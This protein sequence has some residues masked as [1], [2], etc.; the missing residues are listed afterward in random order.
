[1]IALILL[2]AE[3]SLAGPPLHPELPALPIHLT[4]PFSNITDHKT[5]SS[6]KE[7]ELLLESYHYDLTAVRDTQLVP[8]VFATDIPHHLASLPVPEKTSTF[9]RLLL[10]SVVKVNEDIE[11][12]RAEVIVLRDKVQEG[13]ALTDEESGWLAALGQDYGVD[14]AGIDDV[15]FGDLLRR[16]DSVPVAMVMA[17]GIDE[18][19]W[20]TSRFAIEGNALYGQH[21]SSKGGKSIT[22]A[23]GK[24]KVAAFDDIY[25]STASYIHNLNATRA[26]ASFRETRERMRRE[27]ESIT[28]LEMVEALSEYSERGLD[29]VDDLKSIIR[30]YKLDSYDDV[31]LADTMNP[32]LVSF[33]D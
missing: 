27:N 30:H 4:A 18:S 24:V 19:G 33:S 5:Y 31:S 23:S 15:G 10:P 2:V 12:V 6:A 9:I 28:G 21:L 20:G 32:V 22:S 11:A 17:Q 3:I 29:Y 13:G 7:F 26:Y 25:H 14:D 16:V 8:Q 1:M